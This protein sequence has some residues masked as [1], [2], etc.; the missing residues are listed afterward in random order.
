[1]KIFQER[2]DAIF[3]SLE[4]LSGIADDTFI[5]GRSE[6]AHNQHIIDVLE[7]ARK[8]NV[9]FNPTKLQFKVKQASFFG[10]TWTPDGLIPFLR[11]FLRMINYLNRF[12]LTLAQLS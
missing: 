4:G 12:S 2:M 10:L 8:N 9:K 6:I 11:S 5:D 7:T 3:G 1:M